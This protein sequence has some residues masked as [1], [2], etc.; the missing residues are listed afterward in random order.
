MFFFSVSERHRHHVLVDND[1]DGADD[2]G[3]ERGRGGSPR[4]TAVPLVELQ[5]VSLGIPRVL[6]LQSG[7]HDRREVSQ[8]W[9]VAQNERSVERD[10]KVRTKSSFG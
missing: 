9:L 5:A 8:F 2:D 7:V 10:T 1:A 4:G 6:H 3:C